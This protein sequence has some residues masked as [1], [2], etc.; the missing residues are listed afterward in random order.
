MHAT[1][2]SMIGVGEIVL[3]VRFLGFQMFVFL[4]ALVFHNFH[5][6]SVDK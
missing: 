5:I 3:L 2:G 4:Y 1:A 6:P